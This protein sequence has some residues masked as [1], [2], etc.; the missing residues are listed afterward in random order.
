MPH[1]NFNCFKWL[2]CARIYTTKHDVCTPFDATKISQIK[3]P[4]QSISFGILIIRIKRIIASFG[5]FW[6]K[7]NNLVE[8]ITSWNGDNQ[9]GMILET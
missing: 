3:T 1:T 8:P 7:K 2:N 5:S 9:L 6:V 4:N